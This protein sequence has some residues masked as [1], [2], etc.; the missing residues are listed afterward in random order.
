MTPL[1]SL[2][3]APLRLALRAA[4]ACAAEESDP[5]LRELHGEL[6]RLSGE[7][8][9][10]GALGE[11]QLRERLL[12][13]GERLC[14]LRLRIEAC[15]CLGHADPAL[16]RRAQL[17]L[18]LPWPP[19][20]SL[21]DEVTLVPGS[22]DLQAAEAQL[23]ASAALLGALEAEQARE[24]LS[25]LELTPLRVRLVTLRAEAQALLE[26]QRP[27]E[28]AAE[29]GAAWQAEAVALL[30]RYRAHVIV[31]TGKLGAGGEDPAR[32]QRLLA[33]LEQLL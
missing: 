19:P 17:L 31:A 1:G 9:G 20:P 29:Q 12:C 3:R 13:L 4:A 16:S 11:L 32:R 24:A 27:R 6:T 14:E 26:R 33:P 23:V 10:P 2:P 25:A 15:A 28:A 22:L 21:S 5:V 7:P 30:A 18:A 8:A